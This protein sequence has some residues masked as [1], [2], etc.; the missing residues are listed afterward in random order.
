[1]DYPSI[2]QAEKP[3]AFGP[4]PGNIRVDVAIIGAGLCGLLTAYRLLENGVR[5]IAVIEEG[6]ICQGTSAHTTA[7]ITSQ[8]GLIY[9]K[10]LQGIGVEKARQYALANQAAVEEFYMLA[11]EVAPNCGFERC[12]ALL[13]ATKDED[14][15]KLEKEAEAALR[16]G[17]P[18]SLTEDT[19]LPFPVAAAE[20]FTNQARFH[21]LQFAYGLAQRLAGRGVAIYT[22]T[23][24]LHAAEGRPAGML[25]TDKGDVQAAVV[26]SAAHF[27]FMDKP[28]LYFAR[29]WQERSYVLALRGVPTMQ[30]V[31]LGIGADELSFR[32]AGEYLLFGGGG[33]KTGHEGQQAHFTRLENAA[34]QWY[35]HGEVAAQWSA[36]DCMTHDGIPY[37]GRYRQLE[38]LGDKKPAEKV[39]LATGFNKWGMSSSMVA[40]D[41]LGDEIAGK[42][43]PY[44]AVFSPSRF[45]P[46]LKAKKFFIE[47]ADMLANYIGGYVQVPPDQVRDLPAGEGRILLIDGERVGVYKES[48]GTLYT[49][50][51]YCTHMGCVLDWNADES[52][53]DCPCHGSRYDYTG[54]IINGPAIEPLESSTEEHSAV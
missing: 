52:S 49:I 13:Y 54:R 1:M 40:A 31:Y 10:L 19:E 26:V 17:L 33:H 48:D 11:G 8:H 32:P 46:G 16:L 14:R 7:K 43:N 4:M 27:P 23:K 6:E 34:R 5:S 24:A 25:H 35:P 36:Q 20:R 9:D 51:P 53:W 15:R 22:G 42:E 28:G 2:W 12:D 21:P 29:L 18:A 37:I 50:K 41:I 39:Y 3:P 44:A 45:D 47:T 30:H 38:A